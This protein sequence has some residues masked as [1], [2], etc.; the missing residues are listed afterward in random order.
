MR[1]FKQTGQQNPWDLR[2]ASMNGGQCHSKDTLNNHGEMG[3]SCR[4]GGRKCCS[5]LQEG[6]GRGSREQQAHQSSLIL[7]ANPPGNHF[8]VYGGQEGD[9]E[10]SEWILEG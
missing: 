7:G 10:W 5:Y 6:Q 9:L 3:G 2:D 4:L 8:Q 1:I